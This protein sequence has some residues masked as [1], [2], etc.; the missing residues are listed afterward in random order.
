MIQP[1]GFCGEL[2]TRTRVRGV[3]AAKN[4]SRS[5]RQP[6]LPKRKG[7]VTTSAPAMRAASNT[8]VQAGEGTTTS[9]PGSHSAWKVCI[10][11]CMPPT[12]TDTRSTS[13]GVR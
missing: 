4:S 2:T 6:W 11:A 12:L 13:I 7:T 3:T 5:R 8:L 10:T 1:V 9:S